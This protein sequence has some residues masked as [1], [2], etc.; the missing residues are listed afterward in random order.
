MGAAA[1]MLGPTTT[2]YEQATE[3]QQF[4]M[5]KFKANAKR[6][7][8]VKESVSDFSRK[9]SAVLSWEDPFKS[10]YALITYILMVL[11]M[12]LWALPILPILLLLFHGF[13]RKAGTK[14][15]EEEDEYKSRCEGCEEEVS[16]EDEEEEEEGE[17]EEEENWNIAD[18]VKMVAKNAC[19]MQKAMGE[20]ADKAESLQ[21]LFNCTVPLMS[22]VFG[23]ALIVIMLVLYLVGFRWMI[24]IWGVNKFRKGLVGQPST[25]SKLSNLLT[26]VPNSQQLLDQEELLATD[27]D[28]EGLRE[29][30][31]NASKD[32]LVI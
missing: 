28:V 22:T 13:H 14:S 23:L 6:L 10:T 21:N 9:V 4:T 1:A 2:K 5:E 32:S 16:G 11:Y 12:E 15:S 25:P 31:S 30:R 7:K 19:W 3:E 20:L 27:L 18:R 17:G 29:L 8:D 24:L 26:R